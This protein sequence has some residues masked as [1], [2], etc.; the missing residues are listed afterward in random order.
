MGISYHSI[1]FSIVALWILYV[2]KERPKDILLAFLLLTLIFILRG[3]THIFIGIFLF[4][5]VFYEYYKHIEPIRI[6]LISL[7]TLVI[8]SII[9]VVF[10]SGVY[11]FEQIISLS[12]LEDIV[13]R[14]FSSSIRQGFWGCYFEYISLYSFFTGNIPGYDNCVLETW[15]LSFPDTVE[16]D[17]NPDYIQYEN[18][19]FRLN[20]KIGGFIG[21]YYL[22]IIYSFFKLLILRQ[23]FIILIASLFFI[24]LSTADLFFFLP[25]DFI[26]YFIVIYIFYFN[27]K[28]KDKN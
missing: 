25:Y 28:I 1:G 17:V 24:R 22:M 15:A 19:F 18:S 13:T 12:F 27:T 8:L 5:T 11:S 23:F 9:S 2:L 7:L 4:L 3:R 14:G 26:F 16:R 21:L 20:H 10:L 6:F